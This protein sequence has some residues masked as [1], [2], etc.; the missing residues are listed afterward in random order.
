M[1]AK[2]GISIPPRRKCVDISQLTRV[3]ILA[4]GLPGTALAAFNEDGQGILKVVGEDIIEKMAGLL[5]VTSLASR[6][7]TPREL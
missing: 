4:R 3:R 7:H 1:V 2:V 5:G 6:V